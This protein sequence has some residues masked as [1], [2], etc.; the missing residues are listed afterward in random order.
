MNTIRRTDTIL[1]A[2]RETSGLTASGLR[3]GCAL[4][5]AGSACA[6]LAGG[7]AT[8]PGATPP[9]VTPDAVVAR[10][11][12]HSPRLHAATE[13]LR[14]AGWRH[15]QA[16]AQGGPSLDLRAGASHYAGLEEARLGPSLTIPEIQDRYQASAGITVPLL[17]GGRVEATRRSTA[18][19]ESAARE[20]RTATRD[21]LAFQAT[22][23]YWTWARACHLA[24]ALVAAVARMEA[25]AADMAAMRKAGLATENDRLATEVQLDQTRLRLDDCRRLAEQSLAQIEFL[26]GEML[27]AGSLPQRPDAEP[28]AA[29]PEFDQALAAALTNRA[30][31]LAA[32]D[33][34]QAAR[35]EIRAARADGRPQVSLAARYEQGRPNPFDFPPED[36]WDDDA[37]LGAT[38]TWSLWDGGLVRAKVGEAR[39]RAAQ[40][41]FAE[42]QA[43]EQAA[44]E[45]R[46]ARIALIN[47]VERIATCRH[48]ESAATLSARSANDLWKSGLARHS[49]VL[50][51]EA[52]LTDSR[53]QTID[54]AC[55]VRT[56]EARLCYATGTIGR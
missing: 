54:A 25:L 2:A 37:F 36:E 45:V 21:E 50:D 51:A 18:W 28:G 48:A 16:W 29:V 3:Y 56:A 13:A 39:A 22:A 24:D 32:K 26:T 38:L 9:V 7:N 34:F 4:L 33:R 46:M 47:A 49:D 30:D 40:A 12:A 5:L 1:A 10:T 55:D 44:L 52:R 11:L 6:A 15:R 27:P 43:A 31:V 41:S 14:A 8:A 35:H 17:T 23:A 53:F 42:Q 20:S 19:T